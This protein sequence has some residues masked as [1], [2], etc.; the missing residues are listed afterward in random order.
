MHKFTYKDL[1]QRTPAID[2]LEVQS[3]EMNIYLVQI[4]IGEKCGFVYDEKDRPMRFF[5]AGH[6]REAFAECVVAQSVMV[7]DTPYEEMIGNPPKSESKM[8]LP[9]TMQ[10]PY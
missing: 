4:T 2:Y 1:M 9:F 7:H 3:F 10:L 5:S 6:I 8:A